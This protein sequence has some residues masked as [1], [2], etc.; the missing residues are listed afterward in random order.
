M[1]FRVCP[2]MM[3]PNWMLSQICRGQFCKQFHFVLAIGGPEYSGCV[4]RP[5]II[6]LIAHALLPIALAA[7]Q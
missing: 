3:L 1:G 2:T 7:P 4:S 6:E 5:Q